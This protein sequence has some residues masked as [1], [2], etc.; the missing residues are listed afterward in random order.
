MLLKYMLQSCPFPRLLALRPRASIESELLRAEA[1]EGLHRI[2]VKLKACESLQDPVG[3]GEQ[4]G[5][6]EGPHTRYVVSLRCCVPRKELPL[7]GQLLS[8]VRSFLGTASGTVYH[9][10]FS[11]TVWPICKFGECLL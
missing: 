4:V 6:A 1:C 8:T 3:S 10:V 5:R 9:D 7:L 11:D 2:S